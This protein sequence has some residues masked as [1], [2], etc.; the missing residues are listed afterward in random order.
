MYWLH[1]AAQQQQLAQ[2]EED[3]DQRERDR[4]HL[5]TSLTSM[6]PAK[7]LCKE[8]KIPK[9]RDYYGSGWVG[10]GLTRIFLVFGKSSQNSH[11]P[12]LIFWSSIPRVFC[13]YALHKFVGYYDL[14]VLSMSVM[15]F[16]KKRFG[17]RVS[18]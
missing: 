9:I 12:V 4:L 2:D 5:F 18:G 17:W 16:Q 7:R 3:A 11:K 10:Q 13:L 15:G 14:S 6:I 8:N 1:L